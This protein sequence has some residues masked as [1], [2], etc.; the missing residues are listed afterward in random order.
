MIVSVISIWVFPEH[1]KRDDN[2]HIIDNG[3]VNSLP[4]VECHRDKGLVGDR[5][6]GS[7]PNNIGQ[8]TFFDKKVADAFVEEF[9]LENFEISR[10]RRNIVV[11]GIVLLDL[12]DKKFRMGDVKLLGTQLCSPCLGMTKPIDDAA[13]DW[14][15]YKGGGLRCKVLRSGVFQLGE[16]EFE[17]LGD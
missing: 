1:S 10:F 8:V 13:F 9:N 17:L 3:I 5:Y 4:T 14:L 16:C 7:G 2:G 12:V 15:L 6:Y 11:N